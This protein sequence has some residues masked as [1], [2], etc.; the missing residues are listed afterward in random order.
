MSIQKQSS[1]GGKV[2]QILQGYVIC[3]TGLNEREIHTASHVCGKLGGRLVD[4]IAEN[5]TCLISR[6]VGSREYQFAV[7]HTIPVVSPDWLI[8]CYKQR[9]LGVIIPFDNYLLQAFSGLTISCTQLSPEERQ[10]VLKWVEANGG[11]CVFDLVR[12]SCTHLVAKEASGD[13]YKFAKSWGNVHIVDI[14]WIRDCVHKQSTF[15][16]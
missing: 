7:K 12:D 13:K 10:K 3:F 14:S 4:R 5:V 11:K 8:D 16:L 9:T 6:R 2:V 15:T 1:N